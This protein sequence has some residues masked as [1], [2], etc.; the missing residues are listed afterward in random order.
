MDR[1]GAGLP[2]LR[3]NRKKTLQAKT[4]SVSL[5]KK[6]KSSSTKGIALR[7]MPRLYARGVQFDTSLREKCF[8]R[9]TR[10]RRKRLN[11]FFRWVEKTL[12]GFFYSL[13]LQAKTCS[14]FLFPCCA[15]HWALCGTS[16]FPFLRIIP[17]FPAGQ[18]FF[19]SQKSALP[20]VLGW[21]STSR[22][23]LTPVRYITMRS[24]PR[25]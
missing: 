25:P 2:L 15:G 21:S 7:S 3:A 10:R 16:D 19:L 22:I 17:V 6:T 23:L 12:R 1:T 8:P 14:V 9:R 13:T 20:V 11:L 5:S 24:K 4:C 18:A